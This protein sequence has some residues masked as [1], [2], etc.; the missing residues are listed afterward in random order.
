MASPHVAG[1]SA[2]V[3]ER[4][5]SDP[6][7][8]GMDAAQKNAVVTNFL[9]G[10]AHPLIDVELGDGTFYSPRKVGAGQVD[11][12]A[13]TTSSVYPTV[14]GASDPSRPKADLGDGTK[15]WTFQV[16]LTNIAPEAR[17]YTLGGQALSEVVEEGMFL[18]HSQNWAGQ[19]ISL[20]FSSDSVTV[21]ASSS[22][23]VTIT[24]TPEAELPRTLP[25]TPPK[26]TFIDGAV[27]SRAPTGHPT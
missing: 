8:G 3:R 1:I 9:M 26:G 22:A 16:Q 6:L 7:F 11:A 4:I 14:I 24:V 23:T 17:T 27:T 19:G 5:A 25:K 21:L 13:A 15:G 2:L 18:E 10:T 20:T 12:V